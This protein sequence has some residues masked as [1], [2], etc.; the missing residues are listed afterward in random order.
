MRKLSTGGEVSV[1][2]SVQP[3]EQRRLRR[4]TIQGMGSTELK[5]AALLCSNDVRSNAALHEIKQE[6]REEGEQFFFQN[7]K[8]SFLP[9]LLFDFGGMQRD[10]ECR[11]YQGICRR[12]ERPWS[13]PTMAKKRVVRRRKKTTPKS[14]GLTPAE[15]QS[16]TDPRSRS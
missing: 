8:L 3:R 7:T 4:S 5:W 14:I 2:S 6:K 10:C 9:F 16:A 1:E 11:R 12:W 15:T 13:N